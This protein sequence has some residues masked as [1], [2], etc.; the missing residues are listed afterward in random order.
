M[1]FYRVMKFGAVALLG[2]TTA[3]GA[4]AESLTSALAYAYENNPEIASS[5]VSVRSARQDVVQAGGAHLPTIGAQLSLNQT[6]TNSPEG[7]GPGGIP[8]GGRS[9]N[10]SDS[11]GLNY[12][13]NLWDNFASD[14]G[15]LAAQAAYEAQAYSAANTEQT[16]LLSAATSY[17]NV[18]RDRRL[19][20]IAEENL[21]FVGAQ[22]QSARDRL[23][24]GEG[25]ELDVA[26]AQAAVAQA[27]AAFQAARASLLSS[28]ASYQLNV[29]RAPGSLSSGFT[30]ASMPGSIDSALA[31]AR[32]GHPA[33]LAS[34][35][36]VRA[37]AHQA[38]QV[39]AS[40]GP[41]LSLS[42]G[43]GVSGFTGNDGVTQQAQI[44]LNLSVP[45]FTPTRDPSVERANLARI[46][47]ELQSLSTY[48]TLEEA[49]R[50]GWAGVQTATAQI[51]ATT[52]AVAASRL[53]LD[54]VIDQNE[55]GQATTLDVLDAR[56]DLLA[57]EEQLVQAQAQRALASYS[58]LSATGRMTA[59]SLGLPVQPRTV[60]GD[61]IV[62]VA[63]PETRDAWSGLR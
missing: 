19:V 60:E 22:L 35:A 49:I 38:D 54:A 46:S 9:S 13:Q 17:F 3:T 21:G 41:Q 45:I 44:G 63:A 18:L 2:L 32:T 4:Q 16:V 47:S 50:S 48:N 52:A 26:Q 59:T 43:A 12:S 27:T 10:T 20:Q 23:E 30:T 56:A 55:L 42:A 29:G 7:V 11:I 8:T 51:E 28:E 57:A 33:L 40:F 39:D 34:Q 14:A 6:F 37:A 61:V 36:Q 58:L 62:P 5:F 53:A 25:T 1:L 15:M 31:A 24:L